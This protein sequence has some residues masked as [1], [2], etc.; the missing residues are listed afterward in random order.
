MPVSQSLCDF[1]RKVKSIS[2]AIS[3]VSDDWSSGPYEID[4]DFD[5]PPEVACPMYIER[6]GLIK[7]DLLEIDNCIA[8]LLSSEFK[9]D[10][11]SIEF[12]IRRYQGA[13]DLDD[14]QPVP[15]WNQITEAGRRLSSDLGRLKQIDFSE[16]AQEAPSF[17]LMEPLE[18]LSW[19]FGAD[20]EDSYVT[21]EELLQEY[22]TVRD[23]LASRSRFQPGSSSKPEV[24][25]AGNNSI[26][27]TP[28]GDAENTSAV[29][30]GPRGPEFHY[31]AKSV[32]KLTSA[33]AAIVRDLWNATD[34][35][36]YVSGIALAIKGDEFEEVT[37]NSVKSHAS[38]LTGIFEEAGIPLRVRFSANPRL[39]ISLKEVQESQ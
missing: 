22:F 38:R 36:L 33:Q 29:P 20:P 1:Y 34:H 14:E 5:P 7:Q 3:R 6:F 11:D 16:L 31:G 12:V 4:C 13:L 32:E 19:L 17:D 15:L 25:G 27:L 24:T 18:N 26:A 10:R 23:E 30:D 37:E 2:K 35:T 28:G 8:S 9:P 39:H 21:D